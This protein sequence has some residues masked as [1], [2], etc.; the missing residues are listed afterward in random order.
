MKS[1]SAML[2][3]FLVVFCWSDYA[4]SETVINYDDGSTYT[5]SGKE[6]IYVSSQPLWKQ[7]TLNNGN[8]VQSTKQNPWAKRDHVPTPVEAMQPGSHD[9][10]LAYEPWSE[11]LTFDMVLWQRS[12]D[13]NNDGKYG[14]GDDSFDASN[15]A[16]VCSA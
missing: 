16:G 13:T 4:T 12:C 9:W 2:M 10:C 7:R 3:S 14:C 6:E 8:L 15:D 11:G 5:L 1:V